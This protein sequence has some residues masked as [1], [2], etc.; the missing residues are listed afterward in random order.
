MDDALGPYLQYSFGQ[1]IE[2][3]MLMLVLTGLVPAFLA[4]TILVCI[5]GFACGEMYVRAQ[6]GVKRLV[7]VTESP[8][9]SHFNDTISGVIT[10]RAFSCQTRFL[11][12]NLKKIDD[13][14]IP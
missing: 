1:V 11:T 2:I 5:V 12:E 3:F 14:T 9:I 13:Y 8:L 10:I 4:P 6:M 7:S